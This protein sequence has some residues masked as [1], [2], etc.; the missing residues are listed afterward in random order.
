MTIVPAVT[1]WID[2][3]VMVDFDTTISMSKNHHYGPS[4]VIETRRSMQ[5]AAWMAMACDEIGSVSISFDHE[6]GRKLKDEA[7]PGTFEGQWTHV[8][9]N[10][11]RPTHALDGGCCT[12]AMAA[13]SK[14]RTASES[15]AT[16]SGTRS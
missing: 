7:P 1:H 14:Q 4:A 15:P 2:T 3:S 8:V 16:T 6:H 13:P 12:P 9:M 10:I 5:R 11:V